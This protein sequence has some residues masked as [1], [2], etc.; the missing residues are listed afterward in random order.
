MELVI[1]GSIAYDDL[2][3]DV[4]SAE[5]AL[6]GS[7]TYA[8]L[9]AAFHSRMRDANLGSQVPVG[10]VGVVGKDFRA[11][12]W[13][14]LQSRGLNMA[15]IERAEGST[16]RWSGRYHGSMD[17]AETLDTQLNVFGEF[18]PKIPS[19]WTSPEVLFC[20]NIHPSIQAAVL[21]S[22]P[23][24]KFTALDSMNLWI[25][26]EMA[27]L[28]GVLRRVDMA[29]LNDQEVRMLASDSNLIRAA[30]SIRTGAALAASEN[31]DSDDGAEGTGPDHLIV[32]KGE[33]GVLAFTPYGMVALPA[34]PTADAVDPT[35]CG[36]SFAG[37]L[38]S[39]LAALGSDRPT[40]EQIRE[41][42]INAVV[43]ASFTLGEFG[44]E[45]L[46]ALD[47]ADYAARR[48]AYR[49]IAGV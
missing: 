42:I 6:G 45:G 37:A 4:G 1:V 30:E 47:K 19:D 32:K 41:A 8:G 43:T 21:D 9:S 49:R 25:K 40:V 15:G 12:D 5:G 20:A 33:N 2:A 38:L 3:T 14:M 44:T 13:E 10:L 39:Y 18:E 22:C 35:G 27:S 34:M 36:D 29:I 48:D 31:S 16:F 23:D 17:E 46:V 26:T 11:G 28:S 24:A 7:A